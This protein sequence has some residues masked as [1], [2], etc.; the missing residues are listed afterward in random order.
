M[1]VFVIWGWPVGRPGNWSTDGVFVGFGGVSDDDSFFVQGE[2]TKTCFTSVLICSV[3][4]LALP[5]LC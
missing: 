4:P 5:V 3:G 2:F 1:V